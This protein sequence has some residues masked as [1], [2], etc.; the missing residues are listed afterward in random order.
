MYTPED[1]ELLRAAQY[2]R[3]SSDVQR[4]S[5]ENQQ[6]A[7]A[8]Y[9]LHHGYNI[10]ASYRDAGKSGLSLRGRAALRQLL[11]DALSAE[12]PF[13]VI[14]VLD[15]SRWGRFQNPDQ[16]GHY[17]FLCRQAGVPVIYCAEPF[18]NDVV[19]ATTI[20]KHLKRVMAGEYSRDLSAKVRRAHH[21][22]A[23]L[24]FRQGGSLTYGFRRLLVDAS[25]KPRQILGSGERKALS[26][27]KVVI[28]PGPPEELEVIRRIF[29]L[30]VQHRL[31]IAEI[32]RRLSK[33]GIPGYGGK[34]LGH[35]AVRHILSCELCIGQMTYNV[36][37]SELQSS[38][39]RNP[40]ELWARFSAFEP[41]V[42]V[43]QFRKA[44]ERLAQFP[45]R[46]DKVSIAA[47]LRALLSE[48][49]RL[50]E[51][52]INEAESAPCHE[53]IVNHFG[54]LDAAYAAVG[55]VPKFKRLFGMNGRFWGEKA[56]FAGLRRL[57]SHHG[58]ISSHLIDRC[59]DLP[60]AIYIRKR[61][62]ALSAAIEQAGLPP[63]SRS[64]AQ[65]RAWKRRRA[66]GC[67]EIYQGV[68]WSDERLARALRKLYKEHGYTTG[69][70]INQNEAAPSADYYFKRFGSLDKA[71][72]Y[73]GIP[74]LTL[75]QSVSA[76]RKRKR[77]GK[78]T[79]KRQRRHPD[80]SIGLHYRS[81][82][83]LLGLSNLVKKTGVISARLINEDTG[84]PSAD[85]VIKH[86]GSLREAYRRAGIVQL[87]GKLVR[88]GLPSCEVNNCAPTR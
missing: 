48:K 1:R 54:S 57:H 10:V 81:D 9:A 26:T 35:Q 77:D 15:V 24:G 16:A 84:L 7:I 86:F 68:R 31:S 44:Q 65:K 28:V 76:A 69:N 4:H 60:S 78:T 13:D 70:L 41:V 63:V 29:R 8:E 22:Q 67:D 40:E 53:T 3:M 62:G 34:S 27:D 18:S 23:L 6:N 25:R 50:T 64:E 47:S 85:C 33:E 46:W 37:T 61:F 58:F 32:T 45:V 71:R 82:D 83:I 2:L 51:T 38:P 12:R 11:S 87:E 36:T 88:F 73:A 52:L 19:P 42:T 72:R 74:V 80:Q 17:E 21:Q 14:L 20:V 30:Y 43:S 75:S 79:I 66:A 59:A 5:T 55:Y 39:R 49:G 56:L